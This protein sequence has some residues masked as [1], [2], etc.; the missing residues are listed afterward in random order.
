MRQFSPL[1]SFKSH[2]QGGTEGS[3]D[4]SAH[5]ESFGE[6]IAMVCVLVG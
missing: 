1:E 5:Y 3:D 2:S 6:L 4:A